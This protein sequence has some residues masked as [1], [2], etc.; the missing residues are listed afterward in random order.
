M[1]YTHGTSWNK[2]LI[3]EEIKNFIKNEPEAHNNFPSH[4]LLCKKNRADLDNA[5]SRSGGFIYWRKKM[6]YTL[7]KCESK[8][9]WDGERFIEELLKNKGYKVYKQSVTC[10]YDYVVNDCVRIDCKYSHV[11]HSE[12][13]D[14]FSCHLDADKDCDIFI[15][16]CEYD[17]GEHKVLVIPHVVVFNQKQISIG[18]NNSKWDFYKNKFEYI[19]KYEHFYKNLLVDNY[20]FC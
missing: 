18:L 14:F 1:G 19:D 16:L 3:E 8:I 2:N 9:G 4:H 11:Y 20:E 17:N 6:G 12:Q 15:V 7:N 13:G 10:Y 5:I